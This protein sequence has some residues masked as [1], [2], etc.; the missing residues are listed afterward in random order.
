VTFNGPASA[1]APPQFQVNGKA[2]NPVGYIW[3]DAEFTI[4]GDGGG[5]NANIVSFNGTA[6]LLRE[7]AP[8]HYQN[9]TS[10][11]DFGEATGESS[12]GV[13]PTYAGTT[14]ILH[15]GASMLYGLWNT[16]NTTFGPHVLPG[17]ISIDR[18]SPGGYGFFFLTNSTAYNQASAVSNHGFW[19]AS[20]APSNVIGTLTTWMPPAYTGNPYVLLFYQNGY[21]PVTQNITGNSSGAIAPTA[22]AAVFDTPVYLE[23]DAQAA[24]FGTSGIAGVTYSGTP[25][26]LWIT[27]T[28]ENMS[29][30]FGRLNDFRDPTFM[31]FAELRLN[32]SIYLDRF[33][34]DPASF[35]WVTDYLGARVYW[36]WTE[37]YFFNYGTGTFSVNNTD[38]WGN[39]TLVAAGIPGGLAA[40]EFFQTQGKVYA[41][42]VTAEED[43][44][45]VAVMFT[46]AGA[47]FTNV[48]SKGGADAINVVQ[49][50][51]VNASGVSAIARDS[52]G[53][54]SWGALLL[55][56][57]DVSINGVV[58]K[59]GALGAAVADNV[60][61]LYIANVTASGGSVG[62]MDLPSSL[63][64]NPYL[65]DA[66]VNGAAVETGSI[67]FLLAG[68]ASGTN[69]SYSNV[70]VTGGSLGGFFDPTYTYVS[71]LTLTNVTSSGGSWGAYVFYT[72]G[73][74]V[75]GYWSTGS[76]PGLSSD[77]VEYFNVTN[78]NA[79]A[80]SPTPQWDHWSISIPW[81]LGAGGTPT[82]SGTLAVAGIWTDTTFD[83]L[84]QNV[85]ALN[86]GYGYLDNSTVIGPSFNITLINLTAW[87][88][89]NGIILNGTELP[90]VVQSFV[91][92][93]AVGILVQDAFDVEIALTTVEDAQGF[94]IDAVDV[95]NMIDYVNN[96]V[97]N[98]G[99]S[100][101]GT[102][103]SND[104][105][106]EVTASTGIFF[107]YSGIGNY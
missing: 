47:Q 22:N 93:G 56:A 23:T 53:D 2:Y 45:G 26:T 7:V 63:S 41:Y 5:A 102:F 65:S 84:I 24:A 64:A 87:N 92:G 98:N 106:A 10:A 89:E 79:S 19:N 52:I 21:D 82:I 9:V 105:Q 77:Y 40:V 107:N 28:E 42:N 88:D 68:N 48:T 66:F 20:Y 51:H 78:V 85:S 96:F 4:G 46:N 34:Q 72:L 16:T 43:C 81:L 75:N 39:E 67:G 69:I 104:V 83:A 31:S 80:L 17:A 36:K 14:E 76:E 70:S 44:F 35:H 55:N 49:A 18:T 91:D 86:L 71:H 101:D 103:N 90:F 61:D 11:Y 62:V 50:A 54:P 38:I 59:S 95:T 73:V 27:N 29:P 60:T 25:A 12:I 32:T 30:V 97:G 33:V 74:T 3:D 8:G 1:S 100:V 94:A 58:A 57:T 37:G 13:A 6:N 99:A 15:Q